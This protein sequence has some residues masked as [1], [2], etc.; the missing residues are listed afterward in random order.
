[1]KYGKEFEDA[2]KEA[3]E[4]GYAEPDP[5]NDLEGYDAKYK[6][7]ILASLAFG[8][9]IS[10]DLVECEG[11]KK[12]SQKDFQVAEELGF[13]IKLLG[14]AK[15]LKENKIA[16][17]VSPYFIPKDNQISQINGVL[18]GVCIRGD[19]VGELLLTGAGAGPKPTTSSILGDILTIQ[20]NLL[21]DISIPYLNTETIEIEK[22]EYDFYL[23]LE[24]NDQIGVIRDIGQVLA[25][26]QVSMSSIIQRNHNN[27]A[28]LCLLTHKIA[29]DKFYKALKHI[30]QLSTVKKICSTMKVFS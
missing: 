27:A 29:E 5:T 30:E 2:L 14:R 18:N 3:Q 19:L 10:P 12:V 13:S 23:R 4:K 21:A 24:V 26:H 20:Q 8:H 25:E 17:G 16:I 11:I 28:D 1:M 7:A 15:K 9:Y 6:I 22:D